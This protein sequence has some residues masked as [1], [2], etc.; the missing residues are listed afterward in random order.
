[1]GY[2]KDMSSLPIK[3]Y[4]PEEYLE[5]ERTAEFKSEYVS[6]EMLG[7][8]G[9]S[10]A[11]NQI[12]RNVMSRIERQAEAGP[13]QPLGS[14]QKVNVG[15]S[16]FYPDVTVVCGKPEFLDKRKDVLLNPTV[17]V[18]V[19]SPSTEQYDRGHKLNKYIQLAS[20]RDLLFVS[21]D[22]ISIEHL[23]RQPDNTWLLK[24]ITD[25]DAVITLD[26][27]DCRLT[28]ADIYARVEFE[29]PN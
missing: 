23:S 7:M 13:C 18:E 10:F 11:H 1:M 2:N 16:F 4:T 22:E 8:A 27:I 15:A 17:I 24:V 9:A 21:Q 29:S 25:P 26:S 3:R 20:L 28:V 5:I 19:L 14:D 12:A 6:G